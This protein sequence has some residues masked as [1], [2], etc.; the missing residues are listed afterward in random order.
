MT[1]A[2]L[3]L[4]EMTIPGGRFMRIRLRGEPPGVYDEIAAAYGLLESSAERD[5][6]RPSLEHYRRL[7]E[8][9]VLMPVS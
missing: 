2:E 8:I 6:S 7:N 9:D 3:E 5:D 1:A 4:P